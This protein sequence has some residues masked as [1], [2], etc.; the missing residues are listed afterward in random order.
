ME[1]KKENKKE[2]WPQT[3]AQVPISTEKR[4]ETKIVLL[5]MFLKNKEQGRNGQ[6]LQIVVQ[7]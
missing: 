6:E 7:T 2:D 4:E 5:S 1:K 3:L